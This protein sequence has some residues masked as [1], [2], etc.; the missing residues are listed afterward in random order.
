M[1]RTK[2]GNQ[3]AARNNNVKKGNEISSE[4]VEFTTGQQ[5]KAGKR[6]KD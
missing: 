6:L 4:L 2:R 3:N 1:G 5:D